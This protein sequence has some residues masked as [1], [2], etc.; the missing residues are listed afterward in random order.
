MVWWFF[1]IFIFVYMIRYLFCFFVF[2]L[3]SQVNFNADL[4]SPVGI[5]IILAANFGE[6]RT[7]HFHTG[8]DIKTKGQEGYKLYAIADGYVSRIKVSPFGYGKAIYVNHPELGITSVYAHC[9]SFVGEIQD[10]VSQYQKE[11]Q[12]Y[13]MEVFPDSFQLKVKKGQV[14]AISGNTGGSTAPHLHFEIRETNT[15]HPL[16]PL[17]FKSFHLADSR[18]PEIRGLKFYA[19]TEKGYRL[20]GKEKTVVVE[21]VNGKYRVGNNEVVVP[22]HY[23]SE[24]GGVGVAVQVI[25]RY[26]GADNVCGIYEGNLSVNEKLFYTQKMDRLDFEVNRQINTH[27]DYEAF[28]FQ[29]KG[30]EKYFRTPHNHL[31]IYGTSSN[32]LISVVPGSVTKLNFQLKDYSG[33][34]SVLDFQLRVSEGSRREEDT[35]YDKY[36][37][38]YLYPDSIYQFSGTNYQ[39]LFGDYLVYEPVKKQLSYSGETLFFG[40]CKVPLNNTFRLFMRMPKEFDKLS[41]K[42]IVVVRGCN[43]RATSLGGELKEGWLSCYPKEFGVFSVQLDTVSP[44]VKSV[45]FIAN[46]N[47]KGKGRLK[48]TVSDDLSGVSHYAVYING[49]YQVLEYEPKLNQLFVDITNL[50]SGSHK[51][52]IVVKDKVGNEFREMCTIVN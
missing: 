24:H 14:I 48:W 19:L 11:H 2:P 28:K 4:H 40:D 18:S 16:N 33:N 31:P 3:F 6:L 30:Y 41:N 44:Q 22:S 46:G 32:G 10:A 45:N 37:S 13:E 36:D 1:M 5:P 21:N 50:S 39:I 17:L 20:P 7:N 9:Q 34:T 49:E 15:E 47:V 35:P 29:K 42:A 23:C 38:N 51:L 25:D 43:G 12:F 52:E 8:I 27:M 26:D